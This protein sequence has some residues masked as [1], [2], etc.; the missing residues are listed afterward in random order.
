LQKRFFLRLRDLH[1]NDD[2]LNRSVTATCL[3]EP[4]KRLARRCGF[5]DYYIP[6]RSEEE[7]LTCDLC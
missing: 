5:A 3:N 6:N 7:D 1:S 4:G 2:L